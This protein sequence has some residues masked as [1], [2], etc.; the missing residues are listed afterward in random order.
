MAYINRLSDL[1]NKLD[2]SIEN[3]N[4]TN[5]KL[6]TIDDNIKTTRTQNTIV[7]I[8]LESVNTNLIAIN[9]NIDTVNSNLIA[10]NNNIDTTNT[11]I[12][13]TNTKID[14]TNTKIDTTNT[15]ID[16]TNTKID[17]V[18]TNITSTN[19]KIDTTNTKIDT[20]NTNITSTNTKIDALSNKIPIDLTVTSNNLQTI[21]TNLNTAFDNI[22][23]A[24][25]VN[26][27]NST[28]ADGKAYL[29][30]GAGDTSI[31]ATTVD[32]KNGIDVNI[33]GG[34]GA[35]GNAY[36]YNGAGDTSITATTVDAKNGIDTNIIGGSVTVNTISGFATET[37]LDALNNKINNDLVNTD[38]IQVEVKNTSVPVTGTFW[39]T[40]QP[41]SGSVTVN[42]ISGFATETTLDA[43]NSKIN[44]DLVNTDAIQ[45]EVKNTSI[46]VETGLTALDVNITGGSAADGQAYLYNGAGTTP[47]TSTTVDTKNGIDTNIINNI[48]SIA[49][50]KDINTNT[51]IP[52]SSVN[53]DEDGLNR[54]F[55]TC[56]RDSNINTYDILT[57]S[58]MDYD[59]ETNGWNI[60]NDINPNSQR[61]ALNVHDP[62]S[63]ITVADISSTC[64]DIS[65]KL[66]L[67]N[68]KLD[69]V[70]TN[71]GTTNTTLTSTNTKLDTVNTN[72]GTTNTTLTST[73]TKLDT[74]NTNIGTT[75]TTLTSTNTKLDTVNT[76]IGTT[77]TTLSTINGK[78]PSGLSVSSNRLL[79]NSQGFAFNTSTSAIDNLTS[80]QPSYT[81]DVKALHTLNYNHAY[82]LGLGGYLPI[83]S[84]Y[85]NNKSALLTANIKETKQYI[86]GGYDTNATAFRVIAGN[87]TSSGLALD[88]VTGYSFGLANPKAYYAT[89]SAGTPTTN[90]YIDYVDSSGDLVEDAGP[91]SVV[92]GSFTTLPTMISV[93]KFRTT[94]TIGSIANAA[95]SLRISPDSNT[96][97]STSYADITAGIQTSIFTIPNGYE[98]FIT[99]IKAEYGAVGNLSLMKWAADGVRSCIYRTSVP[100]TNGLNISSGYEGDIGGVFVAGESLAFT[101]FDAIASKTVSCCITLR[102]I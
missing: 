47:I 63:F 66:F 101:S 37:T 87:A 98:A 81:T 8:N 46:I 92:A 19:T 15:K 68:N 17:T 11:K 58:A 78:V 60:R 84:E 3:Q 29:Y 36:L 27:I 32:A 90:L 18:N 71:I 86:W 73:N 4:I 62:V 50:G 80:V 33:I 56:S 48:N 25:K 6:T 72:I 93:L 43:L 82:N 21:D 85:V 76:N 67:S 44:N 69:T 75:N 28:D 1:N 100:A 39:Q 16:T 31:T 99:N 70:N 97:R 94:T 34:A 30:N 42:T 95:H 2:I 14:T 89:T 22:N 45:V 7:N 54:L 83:V 9:N 24:I 51:N 79:T 55:I 26:V 20:V 77:N 57:S 13:T 53:I 96:N 10:I 64:A 52:L 65:Y 41:V 12:D 74:V 61:V 102:K 88:G 23:N 49:Y 59:P 40:T 91:Y 5:D 35:N 38:A